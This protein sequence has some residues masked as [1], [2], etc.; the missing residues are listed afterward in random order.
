MASSPRFDPQWTHACGR[1]LCGVIHIDHVERR[2]LWPHFRLVPEFFSFLFYDSVFC[3]EKDGF[4]VILCS[5]HEN[6]N[7]FFVKIE[8]SISQWRP[9]TLTF[10]WLLRRHWY[11]HF[12]KMEIDNNN[13][14][15]CKTHEGREWGA[16]GV[17]KWPNFAWTVR[18][19]ADPVCFSSCEGHVHPRDYER[20][21]IQQTPWIVR[22]KMTMVSFVLLLDIMERAR[23]SLEADLK[24]WHFV[25]LSIV[26]QLS[27][28]RFQNGQTTIGVY[29]SQFCC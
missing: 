18:F 23:C 29:V 21:G 20:D 12:P 14:S 5:S 2:L 13:T 3:V 25:L 1:G 11:A 19:F 4:L 28:L 22:W 8:V 16:G 10:D 26:A 15:I 6:E 17:R 9:H 24:L 7:N 27:V